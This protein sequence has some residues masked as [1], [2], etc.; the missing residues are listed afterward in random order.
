MLRPI[1]ICTCDPTPGCSCEIV[2]TV[3]KNAEA[4]RVMKFVKGLNDS[5][6]FVRSKVLMK[7]PLP[8]RNAVFNMAINHDRQRSQNSMLS[9]VMYAQ[10]NTKMPVQS[11]K[12]LVL[13]KIFHR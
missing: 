4:E 7:V 2:K 8:G 11:H 1:P 13:L 3:R 6:E 9:Q 10:G 12:V 5:F